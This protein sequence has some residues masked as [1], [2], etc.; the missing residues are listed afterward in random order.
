MTDAQARAVVALVRQNIDV[1]MQCLQA[2]GRSLNLAALAEV[3]E[4]SARLCHQ[5]PEAK[6]RPVAY[7]KARSEA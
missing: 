4:D 1:A 6:G 2:E 3:L 7:R 5:R